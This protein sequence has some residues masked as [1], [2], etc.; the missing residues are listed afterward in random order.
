MLREHV[1]GFG[2]TNIWTQHDW[3]HETRKLLAEVLKQH[4]TC[5]EMVH[6]K[7]EKSLNLRG[8]QVNAHHAVGAGGGDQIG[9]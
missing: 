5:R 4:G 8:V 9:H 2:V 6:G 7:I 3:I 1:C